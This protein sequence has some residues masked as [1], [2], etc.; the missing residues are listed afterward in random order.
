M[1]HN[2]KLMKYILVILFCAIINLPA[3][4]GNKEPSLV[5]G[6]ISATLAVGT[7]TTPLL[8]DAYVQSGP[9]SIAADYQLSK[10]FSVS[11]LVYYTYS[12]SKMGPKDIVIDTGGG[13]YR[14]KELDYAAT[15][16]AFGGYVSGHYC[17]VNRGRVSMSC[18]L[19]FG[20]DKTTRKYEFAGGIDYTDRMYPSKPTYFGV[21]VR[22]IDVKVRVT[23]NFS[24]FGG[25]GSG[26]DGYLSAGLNYKITGHEE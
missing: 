16:V 1:C 12:A 19:G 6:D 13:H 5:K 18:G 23:K 24:V 8:E 26:G 21:R 9:W 25:F 17:Y 3:I 11:A 4:A 15:R 20:I 7:F 10:R 22:F 2:T 14:L